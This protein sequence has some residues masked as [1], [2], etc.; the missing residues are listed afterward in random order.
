VER[1]NFQD[2]YLVMKGRH[3]HLDSRKSKPGFN[4][5]EDTKRHVWKVSRDMFPLEIAADQSLL[6]LR[7]SPLRPF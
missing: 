1:A 3:K 6:S 4:K 7:T 2:L 5:L